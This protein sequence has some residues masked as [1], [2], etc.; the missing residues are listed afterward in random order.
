[1]STLPELPRRTIEELVLRYQLEPSMRDVFVEG[2]SD[3]TILRWFIDACCTEGANVEV[4]PIDGVDVPAEIL[5]HYGLSTGNRSEV[6]ALCLELEQQLGNDATCVTG[7]V[8]G[9][10]AAILPD[11]CECGL[12]LKSDYSCVE[13]YLFSEKCLGKMLKLAFPNAKR[14]ASEVIAQLSPVL[15][16]LFLARAANHSL[17]LGSKWVAF[18]GFVSVK[19][20]VVHFRLDDFHRH[21]LQNAGQWH[22]RSEF[23]I[24]VKE[25]RSQLSGDFRYAANGHDAI[26]VLG[27]FLRN[28]CKKAKD[29]DRTQPHLL[30]HLLTC[31]V[32]VADVQE[33]PLFKNLLKRLSTAK[34][35]KGVKP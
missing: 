3:R 22:K 13:M 19:N 9:D 30:V 31:S 29:A 1:M 26:C 12:L 21:Y 24:K 23:E 7:V 5:N 14:S 27:H 32:E 35:G 28:F 16:E 4:Y 34:S 6:V 25:F 2:H 18:D 11:Q 33:E 8:D 20:G 15:R 10:M 17:S